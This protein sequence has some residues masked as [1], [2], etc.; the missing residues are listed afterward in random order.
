M[1]TDT[2]TYC[3]CDAP[4]MDVEHDAGCRRCGRPVNFNATEVPVAIPYGLRSNDLS[5]EP[6]TNDAQYN[7]ELNWI[8]ANADEAEA[9]RILRA[10]VLLFDATSQADG[11]SPTL[12][13]C[14]YTAIVW[15][16]G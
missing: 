7:E 2:T 3:E 9:E 11:S 10:A 1:S 16:R 8:A 14:L 4:V 5:V 6:D 15:E 13:D 12:G